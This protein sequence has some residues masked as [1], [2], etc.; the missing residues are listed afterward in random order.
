MLLIAMETTNLKFAS[1]DAAEICILDAPQNPLT[2]SH[3]HQMEEIL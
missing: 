3:H 1:T 2:H